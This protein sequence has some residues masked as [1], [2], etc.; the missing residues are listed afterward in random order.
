V[1][2]ADGDRRAREAT[3]AALNRAGYATIEVG[4]GAEALRA[5]EERDVR[6]VLLEVDLPDMTGYEVCHELRQ[7]GRGDLAIFF[8]SDIRTEPLDRVAGLLLGADDFIVKPFDAN[9][10][11]AR[12][13][14]SIA[15][16]PSP[17]PAGG[18]ATG[19][20]LTQREYEVLS[21]LAEGTRPKEVA[22]RLS[23]SPKTVGTHIQNLLGK[24]GVHSR[25]ELVARA[26]MLGLVAHA[27]AVAREDPTPL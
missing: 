7:V 17:R 5:V 21:L 4:T 9:E 10:L 23:I 1:V 16:R 18:R 22:Q 6:L 24:V 26:Y 20:S 15:R 27:G 3:A 12:V 11:I 19:P 14:R 13:R 8:V 2:L 25:A